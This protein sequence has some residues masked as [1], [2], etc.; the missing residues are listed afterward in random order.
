MRTA[1]LIKL[2]DTELLRLLACSLNTRHLYITSTFLAFKC[3]GYAGDLRY[4]FFCMALMRRMLY[5]GAF[6]TTN[7]FRTGPVGLVV[8]FLVD[9]HPL[10]LV[11]VMP[12]KGRERMWCNQPCTVLR[13]GDL[14][15]RCRQ[16]LIVKDVP[17]RS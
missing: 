6:S 14:L 9:I 2:I 3:L 17:R 16:F 10:S 5:S 8:G 13:E 11:A 15:H 1:V 7:P 12:G 4:R